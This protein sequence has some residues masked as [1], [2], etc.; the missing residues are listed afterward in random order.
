MQSCQIGTQCPVLNPKQDQRY[1]IG[2]K[3]SPESDTAHPPAKKQKNTK[4][5]GWT[6]P[7]VLRT[8]PSDARRWTEGRR[9]R[10][11]D[12]SAHRRQK[13][14]QLLVVERLSELR[15]ARLSELAR[16]GR[17]V[18]CRRAVSDRRRQT[19]GHGAQP[20][21]VRRIGRRRQRCQHLRRQTDRRRGLGSR[22]L[23]LM[24]KSTHASSGSLAAAD[25]DTCAAV[26]DLGY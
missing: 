11:T 15:V 12:G 14:A 19:D 20:A 22:A 24:Q 25:T 3:I 23:A 1:P 5:S 4:Q 17:R 16:E 10:K 13:R 9:Q 18:L 26:E 7:L 2:G 21:D 6:G 8:A